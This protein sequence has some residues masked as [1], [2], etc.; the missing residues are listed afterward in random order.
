MGDGTLLEEAIFR[1][2]LFLQVRRAETVSRTWRGG[3]L[4]SMGV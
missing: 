2:C 1:N 4:L 3:K